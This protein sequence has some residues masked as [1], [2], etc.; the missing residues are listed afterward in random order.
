MHV[1]CSTICLIN[2]TKHVR[3]FQGSDSK[4]RKSKGTAAPTDPSG[5]RKEPPSVTKTQVDEKPM[6]KKSKKNKVSSKKSKANTPSKSK[7]GADKKS[8]PSMKTK[9]VKSADKRKT[10]ERE[11]VQTSA[12]ESQT[13]NREA[14]AD[15][16]DKKIRTKTPTKEKG[17]TS[18]NPPSSEGKTVKDKGSASKGSSTKRR[19]SK[20]PAHN[21][22]RKS[23]TNIPASGI[24]GTKKMAPKGQT[25]IPQTV[26][27]AGDRRTKRN[28]PSK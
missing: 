27:P 2:L 10:S 9:T 16:L 14:G 24:K 4:K 7:H 22:D 19:A 6:T 18:R 20:S 17:I 13:G 15:G 23:D 3:L 8:P 1:S 25:K 28:K 11:A 21:D 26:S 5:E 12:S